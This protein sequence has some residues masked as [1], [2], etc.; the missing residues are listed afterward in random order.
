MRFRL[1]TDFLT[2]RCARSNAVVG[3]CS[4]AA[5]DPP[6]LGAVGP[7]GRRA[8]ASVLALALAPA[9][10]PHPPPPHPH[11][12]PRS[13]PRRHLVQGAGSVWEVIKGTAARAWEHCSKDGACLPASARACQERCFARCASRAP[14][15]RG[16]PRSCAPPAHLTR[17]PPGGMP[18]ARC[19]RRL[20]CRA[21]RSGTS[22]ASLFWRTG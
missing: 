17:S 20:G 19:H 18:S 15:S 1:R 14:P 4:R 6:P 16:P 3:G 13:D 2:F 10:P 8:D 21:S 11:P 5:R 7:R 22:P 9:H 12:Q